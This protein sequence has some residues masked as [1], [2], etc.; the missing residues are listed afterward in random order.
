[1][2][3]LV[4]A[5][6]LAA[7]CSPTGQKPE[8]TQLVGGVTDAPNALASTPPVS[9]SAPASTP[10]VDPE[11]TAPPVDP[12]PTG[13]PPPPTGIVPGVVDRTSLD[14]SATYRVN[15]AITVQTGALDVATKIVATNT[16]GEGIDRL[17]LNTIAARLG[18]IKI[19]AASVDDLP[20]DVSIKDQTLIV[21]LGGVL[22]DGGTATI[23]IE[24]RATLT[25]DLTGGGWMFTRNK[26]TLAL[27]RWIPWISVA[28]PFSRPNSGEPFVTTS[29]PQVDVEI[30][31]DAPMIL[32][33]PAASIESYAAGAGNDWSFRS[34]NVRDVSVVLSPA[35]RLSTGEVDGIP[36]RV[37]TRLGGL[38]AEQMVRQA[39]MAI[40]NM[41]DLL[42]VAYPWATLT[43]V[44]TTGGVP[45][46]SPGMLWLP[47]GLSS[48]NRAYA[49]YHGAANQWFYGLVGNDQRA[50]PFAD[51]APADLLARTSLGTLRG[52]RCS[53]A[54]LDGS[55]AAY[56]KGCYY[57]VIFVQGG[58][59]LDDV[60]K[61]MGVNAFWKAMGTYLEANRYGLGGT[62]QLL[63]TLRAG[64]SVD[65]MPLLRARFPKLY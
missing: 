1:M 48:V 4:A 64:T 26:G 30:L 55:I 37:Y 33:A 58:R 36:I 63:E 2:A 32:A 47:T 21:P 43:V 8:P 56:S 7:A 18:G 5:V 12:E 17:E 24:Y 46:E 49:I 41:A 42:G 40:S 39:E 6:V 34:V 53:K 13:G 11:T 10:S 14:L 3:A 19:I 25:K 28:E 61:K 31:T 44:E 20:I 27:Y 65:L 57:E 50:E 52:S 9:T 29:S 22:P 23:S 54:A 60:R 62:R 45:L 15:A 59:L 38:P 35:Y 16:S 51:E